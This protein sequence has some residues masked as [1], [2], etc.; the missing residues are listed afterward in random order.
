MTRRLL[1]G[2]RIAAAIWIALAV[3]RTLAGQD[4]PPADTARYCLIVDG[5]LADL[6]VEVDPRTGDTLVAGRRLDE[7]MR[8]A[9]SPYFNL[10]EWR[11]EEP[12]VT[13]G[14]RRYVSY[15]VPRVM[16]ASEMVRV[17]EYRGLPLFASRRMEDDED[18]AVR[19]LATRPGCEFQLF[20]YAPY[21]GSVRGG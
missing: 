3:P 5:E 2:I 10:A 1:H 21:V 13:V 15:G 6:P 7:V 4:H 12:M 19:F 20:W 18:D 9:P 11:F 8:A 16:P 14:G 17:G